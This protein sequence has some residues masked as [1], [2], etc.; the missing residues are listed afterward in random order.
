MVGFVVFL[1]WVNGLF[2]Q[3]IDIYL[4]LEWLVIVVGLD[5]DIVL[6]ED[7]KG[8]FVVVMKGIDFYFFFLQ[9]FEEGGFLFVDVE[10]Q[11]FQYVD[12]WVVF[13]GGFVDVWVGFD[14][15]MV[16]V[17]VELGDKFIYWNVDFNIYGF[18]NVIE[19]FVMNYFDFVQVV[20]DVYEQ[21]CEWVFE[22]FEEMVVLLV[23]VVGID[24]VVV[25]MVIQECLNFD[26]S[27][28]LGE[29]QVVVLEKIVFV[30][31]EFG[32]VQGGQEFVDKVF[33]IIVNDI[34]VKKVVGDE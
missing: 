16:V 22:N 21:V 28:I 8:V 6:L 9:V 17:E 19:D 12:G 3:V 7:F 13:D 2:I 18:F 5:S 15:I 10:V 27:G 1:V 30:F 34:F 11:N 4:Q 33:F 23:E 24:L 14:F 20:V 25:I 26:V 29:D 32:D 31:V